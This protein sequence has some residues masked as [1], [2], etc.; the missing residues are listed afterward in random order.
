[1]KFAKLLYS[2]MILFFVTNIFPLSV[3]LGKSDLSANKIRIL[4]GEDLAARQKIYENLKTEYQTLEEKWK[5]FSEKLQK[6]VN[7]LK[8]QADNLKRDA[9]HGKNSEFVSKKIALLNKL[10][11]VLLDIR[12][13]KKQVLEAVKQHIDFWDKYF[14]S[15]GKIV[16]RVEE[17][18]LYTFS[19]LQ[20]I[21]KKIALEEEQRSRLITK[22]EEEDGIVHR[23]EHQVATKEKDVRQVEKSI[24]DLKKQSEEYDIK[25]D[26]ELLDLEKE[27]T[28]KDKELA[29]I[30]VELHQKE[31]D[32]LDSRILLI[33]DRLKLLR[34]DMSLIRNRIH[35]DKSEVTL[36]EQKN[37]KVKKEVSFKK[38]KLIE[39]KNN[40]LSEKNSTQ[41]KLELLAN[42]Y[43][44]SLANIRQIEDWEIEADTLSAAFAAYSVSYEQ[45][46]VSVLE[47]LLHKINVETALQDAIAEKTAVQYNTVKSLYSITQGQFKEADILD[48]ERAAFKELKQSILSDIKKDKIEITSAHNFIKDQYKAVAN[49]KKQQEKVKSLP[50]KVIVPNQRKYEET[51]HVLSLASQKLDMQKDLSVNLSELYTQLTDIKEETLENVHFIL[52]ELELVGGWHRA[53]KAMTWE[54]VKNILPNVKLF[55]KGIY[56]TIT[57][58][59]AQFNVRIIA[60]KLAQVSFVDIFLLCLFLLFMFVLYAIL[61][62]FLPSIY[63]TLMLVSEDQTNLYRINRLGAIFIGFIIS[64]FRSLYCWFTL[65]IL[66]SWLDLPVVFM[67]AFYTYTIVFWIYASRVL[68]SQFLLIN[69]KSQ[70]VFLNARLIERFSFIFSFFSISTIVILCF[71][72]MFMLV[73]TYQQSEFP[74]ILLRIYHVV[75]FISIVFSI[76]KE[77]L[78]QLLPSKTK[79]GQSIS[80]FIQQYYYLFLI[81]ILGVLIMSDPYLGGYG[82]LIWY[83][84]WN[85]L[86]TLAILVFLFIV[87]RMIRQY[88]SVFF[89]QEDEVS[90]G[91]NE[92]FENAKT[93]YGF[94]VVFLFLSFLLMAIVI[95]SNIWG[96]GFNFQT[97]KEFLGLKFTVDYGG[98]LTEIRISDLLRMCGIIFSGFIIAYLFKRFVLERIFELHYVD[99][100]IQNTI[101]IISKYVIIFVSIMIAFAYAGLSFLVSY[102]LL[103][104]LVTFGWSFK[105]LF[106]DIVAYF[107][108]LVQRPLKLGDFVKLDS[109]TMGVVRKISP[110]AVILRRKNAV[111]IVVP[112]ST[113]LKA[114]LYNWNYTRSYI[115]FSDIL[116]AVPFGTDV[117]QVK[118]LLLK[119]LDEDPEV[120]KVPQ[121][122][123]RLDDFSDKGYVFMVRG[124]LSSGN[125]LRQ[126]D[127]TSNIRF[128]IVEK[129]GQEGIQV[130]EPSIH[131]VL[132]SNGEKPDVLKEY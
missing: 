48:K 95:C 65:L 15:K 10:A 4:V 111:N 120:L 22:K 32:V 72:K 128:S 74:D 36:Y 17:K 52:Q 35:I 132:R 70:F 11:Q 85:S 80:G 129:L 75:I 3:D 38:A 20:A 131:V 82:S 105:D 51:L 89:F 2:A 9:S 1:M 23:Q 49:I 63:R 69:K 86:F 21:T 27:I 8:S 33:Q 119:I 24:E 126:W 87:H 16:E 5:E 122:I 31:A 102:T 130:A 116:F 62:A 106:T 50:S 114:S 30:K 97:I 76:D 64:I 127:I 39:Q 14:A 43:N 25:G 67:L 60:Y 103:V 83:M 113:V 125:T 100:G 118:E 98:R 117:R 73:M 115:G 41:E 54:G 101:S 45:T 59:V 79:F 110:R 12:E 28:L 47:R 121:P 34:E 42:R 46:K 55:M 19:D 58:Y 56:Q 44:I 71:R 92:R 53:T 26:V 112:N 93:W 81:M 91:S 94:Y 90:G 108:I 61:H 88:T 66:S 29:E 18:S 107:F 99:P 78:L 37:N 109:D 57:T 68:L 40:L 7:D 6:K 123:V 124:F 13:S 96:Y 77:E 104:G 84:F